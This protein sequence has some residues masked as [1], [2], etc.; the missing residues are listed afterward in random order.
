MEATKGAYTIHQALWDVPLV[1]AF[2][3]IVAYAKN[4]GV[5][6]IASPKQ[7]KARRAIFESDD[8]LAREAEFLAKRK[9][10]GKK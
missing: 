1:Q 4:Q 9:K 7:I 6:G 3:M 10:N 2:W 8:F 5:E